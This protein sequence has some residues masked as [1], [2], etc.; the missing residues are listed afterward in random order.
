[1]FAPKGFPDQEVLLEKKLAY[2]FIHVESIWLVLGMGKR[3]YWRFLFTKMLENKPFIL[4]EW[5]AL[6]GF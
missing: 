5:R 2:L 3:A 4:A 6:A 1:M